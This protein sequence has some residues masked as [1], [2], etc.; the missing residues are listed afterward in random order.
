MKAPDQSIVDSKKVK[1][2]RKTGHRKVIIFDLDETLVHCTHRDADPSKA[3][4]FLDIVTPKS[5]VKAG[6]NIRLDAIECLR[7]AG[8]YFEVV[9]FTASVKSYADSI[10]N[11]LDP[12]NELIHHRLYRESCIFDDD[13]GFF[14]KDLRIFEDQYSFEDMIII[15]NCVYSF[16]YQLDNG[17]P[18]INF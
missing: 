4:V 9:V 1:L 7:E 13:Q 8:K 16:S 3:D 17:I 10:L 5:T 11:Y 15:D 12:T 2:Q 6:F 14:V 18:C